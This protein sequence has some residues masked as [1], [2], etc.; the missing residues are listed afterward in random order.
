MSRAAAAG[1]GLG[2][3][4]GLGWGLA[5]EPGREPADTEL[6]GE[7]WRSIRAWGHTRLVAKMKY[8]KL[9]GY[10]WPHCPRSRVHSVPSMC[11]PANLIKKALPPRALSVGSHCRSAVPPGWMD[12]WITLC[13]IGLRLFTRH[14]A[15][16]LVHIAGQLVAGL[17]GLA[18]GRVRRV[19]RLPHAP[20]IL[21]HLRRR[22]VAAGR[23][24]RG[25]AAQ[26]R[27]RL[28]RRRVRNIRWRVR[29]S[30]SML[31]SACTTAAYLRAA[32]MA[33]GVCRCEHE[34]PT[35]HWRTVASSSG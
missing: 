14:L 23:Q 30:R 16:E 27:A 21:L 26:A 25:D 29:S 22:G 10:A 11:Q 13:V 2:E 8:G 24:A 35:W 32:S 7:C 1:L 20:H 17:G 3:P 28:R 4:A 31:S 5:R 34:I 33:R 12:V 9:Q 15:P 6:P 18:A 19:A